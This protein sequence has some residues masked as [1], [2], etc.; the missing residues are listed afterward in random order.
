VTQTSLLHTELRRDADADSSPVTL[1]RVMKSEWIKF[2]TLRSTIAVLGGASL[3][4][5]LIAMLIGYNTRHLSQSLDAN[6]IVA[7][8]PMQGYFLGQLLI[9]ALGVLF[10]TGEYSTGMIRATM[11]AVPRRVPVLWAK[12]LVFLGVTLAT[13]IPICLIAFLASEGLISHYRPGISLGSPGALRV[14]LGTAVYLALLGVIGA[15]LGWIVR[16]TPGALV[17]YLATVLVIPVIFGEAIGHWG[18]R[19]AEILP[20]EA[21]ASFINTIRDQP[22]L[23][24]WPGILVMLAWVVAFVAVALWTLRT[25]DA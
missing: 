7:S 10:V 2:R 11:T 8:S 19:V 9:G 3:G 13:M 1:A 4:I 23:K 16:S 6:D 21:G 25:R 22:S 12:L 20:S 24:P 14:V 15:A 5:L 18:K 17:S